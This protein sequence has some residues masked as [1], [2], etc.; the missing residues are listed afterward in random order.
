VPQ[1]KAGSPCNTW[2]G[3]RSQRTRAIGRVKVRQDASQGADEED[4]AGARVKEGAVLVVLPAVSSD[5]API[6][7]GIFDVD[8]CEEAVDETVDLYSFG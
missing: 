8:A 2:R 1:T 3:I 7:E 4:K 6:E 5:D